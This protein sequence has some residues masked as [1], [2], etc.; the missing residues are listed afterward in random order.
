MPKLNCQVIND[1][2]WLRDVFIPTVQKRGAAVLN[3]RK[4]S[5]AMSAAKAAC[6]HM[7]SWW[8]GTADGEWVSMAVFSDGTHYNAPEGVMFSFP[9]IGRLNIGYKISTHCLVSQHWLKL[10]C[11]TLVSCASDSVYILFDA[12]LSWRALCKSCSLVFSEMS[13]LSA[14]SDT[15]ID[16]LVSERGSP[17]SKIM[18]YG[19]C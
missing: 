9:G 18:F 15:T 10:Y 7:K 16:S 14:K 13:K 3:A 8:H 6:D 11:G 17:S 5:S 19:K 1:D 12:F 2:D 4:A